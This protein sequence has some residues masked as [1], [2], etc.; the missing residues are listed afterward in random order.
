MTSEIKVL[1]TTAMKTSLDELTPE[2]ERA[3]G[4]TLSFV[5]RALG[6]DRQ[7]GGRRRSP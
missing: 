2:F 1:A 7:D 4:N 5:L 6:A 3:T